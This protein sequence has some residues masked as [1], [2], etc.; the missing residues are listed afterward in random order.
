MARTS[1]RMWLMDDSFLLAARG[2]NMLNM[3]YSSITRGLWQGSGSNTQEKEEGKGKGEG[4][5][6]VRLR[7]LDI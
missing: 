2:L 1:F 4:S 5:R 6:C 7:G 3:W